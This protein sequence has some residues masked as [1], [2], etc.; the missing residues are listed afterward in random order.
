MLVLMVKVN[1]PYLQHIGTDSQIK[2][3]GC[4][5]LLFDDVIL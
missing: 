5:V 1:F 3:I 4:L 2:L